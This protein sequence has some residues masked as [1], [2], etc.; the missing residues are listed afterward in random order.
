M[1]EKQLEM[2]DKERETESGTYQK[3]VTSF[4]EQLFQ[5]RRL[6]EA[7]NPALVDGQ[8]GSISLRTDSEP[9]EDGADERKKV[10]MLM[11]KLGAKFADERKKL[12]NQIEVC[13]RLF[14]IESLFYSSCR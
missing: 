11:M 2:R 14:L 1:M 12:E 6:A 9:S 13:L 8:Q 10:Q 7:Y 5:R 4:L 3:S